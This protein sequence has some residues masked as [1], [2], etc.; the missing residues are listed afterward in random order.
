[1]SD[2]AIRYLL[3]RLSDEE[4]DRLEQTFFSDAG[5]FEAML[6]AED[7]L[8]SDYVLGTLAGDDR[9]AFESRFLST[10][11]GRR[12]LVFAE[13]LID[14]LRAAEKT[15]PSP[16]A[17]PR[18]EPGWRHS[19]ILQ[20][21]FAAAAVVLAALAWSLERDLARAR[22][23]ARALQARLQQ[24]RSSS[25]QRTATAPL[26]SPLVVATTLTA[27]LTRSSGSIARLRVP[28]DADTVRVTLVLEREP[29][30]DRPR[31]ALHTA[32]GD[33]VWSASIIPAAGARELIADLPARLLQTADYEIVVTRA[34]L[35]P[36]TFPL[37]IVRP[38]P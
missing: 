1:M 3:G 33:E 5:E 14:A 8:F 20:W 31:V 13:A 12:K 23:D 26:R 34:G 21:T 22:D 37:S 35:R 2:R 11:D 29:P 36:L 38:R 16:A 9:A 18:P 19:L 25:T 24:Q 6:A 28:L 10:P 7:E 15:Q 30:G 17:L 27:G 4:R 32:D